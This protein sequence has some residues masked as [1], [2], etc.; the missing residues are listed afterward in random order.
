[1]SQPSVRPPRQ[2]RSRQSL[3]RVLQAGVEVLA[4]GGYDSFTVDEVCRRAAVSVG[5]VYNRFG[6][7]HALFLTIHARFV[8]GL[9]EESAA[10]TAFDP[11][12]TAPLRIDEVID[13]AVAE[14]GAIFDR[15]ARFLRAFM[16]QAATDAAVAEQASAGIRDFAA[17]FGRVILARSG[18]LTHPD[19][20]LGVDFCFRMVY[21][22]L[23][24][25]LVFGSAFES[26]LA[27]TWDGLVD[28]L[29][30]TCRDHLLTK[31]PV[32]S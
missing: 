19:P 11:D 5:S 30:S 17:L 15:N 28:E 27:L 14:V 9:G 10:A 25:R 24:R 7:K 1:M 21:A 13:G 6:S 8:D 23:W 26:D 22:T 3:E 18:E 4:E 16:L 32:D 20:A 2:E 12:A 31:R 29:G